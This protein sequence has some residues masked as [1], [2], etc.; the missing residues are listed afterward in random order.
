MRPGKP[1]YVTR[2]RLKKKFGVKSIVS[3]G[4]ENLD[5]PFVFN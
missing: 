5:V 4:S 1:M 3:T 2:D